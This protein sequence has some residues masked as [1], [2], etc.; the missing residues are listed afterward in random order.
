[1]SRFSYHGA[2]W[3]PFREMMIVGVLCVIMPMVLVSQMIGLLYAAPL[4]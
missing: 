2:V 1:M 4:A 3:R